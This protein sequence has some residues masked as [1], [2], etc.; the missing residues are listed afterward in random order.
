MGKVGEVSLYAVLR[1]TVISVLPAE[2]NR[3]STAQEVQ[4]MFDCYHEASKVGAQPEFRRLVH[5]LLPTASQRGAHILVPTFTINRKEV[6][7]LAKNAKGAVGVFS[8]VHGHSQG[9]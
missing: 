3:Q 2:T 6:F 1:M 4:M 7:G 8:G 5:F 9:V